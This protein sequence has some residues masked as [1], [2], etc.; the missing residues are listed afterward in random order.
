MI[1]YIYRRYGRERAAMVCNVVTLHRRGAIRL[2]A[3]GLGIPEPLADRVS[4]SL[5][6]LSMRS[7][8]GSEALGRIQGE[9]AQAG[10]APLPPGLWSRWA[11]M[12]E[13]LRGYPRHLSIHSGGFLLSDQRIDQ[14]VPQEPAT[15]PGRTVVQWCKDDLEA[16]NFFKIDILALGMLTAIRK[17]LE[18]LDQDY[19]K[20]MTLAEIPGE[21]RATYE[22]ITKAETIGVFQIES[23]AQRASLPSLRP[24][25]FYDL[26]V[27][28]AIIRPG[29]ILGGV[30][31]PYLKRKRGLEPVTYPSP[32]LEPI[33]NRTFGTIIFQEQLMRVAMAVGGFSGGQADEIRKN[34]GS[35]SAKGNI[36]KWLGQLVEGMVKEGLEPQFI[37]EILR[38]IQGFS[39]YGFPES[40]AASFALLAYSSSWLKRH[41]PAPFF[42]GLLNSQPM[43]FYTPDTLI[44]TARQDGV[45]VRGVSVNHSR[46]ESHLE[47]LPQSPHR[48]ALRLGL[49]LLSDLGEEAAKGLVLE[50]EKRGPY[51]DLEDLTRRT[52]LGRTGRSALA[53]A[54]AF[55]ESGQAR[56]P[57]I[58]QAERPWEPTPAPLPQ[59]AYLESILDREPA[60]PFRPESEM[61]S[62][63]ADYRASGLS[64]GRHLALLIREEAWVYP[65]PV[66]QVTPTARLA[67]VAPGSRITVFGLVLVKQSPG[68]AKKMLFVTLEDEGGT[69]QTT[70]PPQVYGLYEKILERQRFLCLEGIW[71]DQ[72]GSRGLKV[73]RAFAPEAPK[74]SVIHLKKRRHFERL[75][76]APKK[77]IR[78]Y[79]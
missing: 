6:T 66:E 55:S 46:W 24:D 73:I 8:V 67:T 30:K 28:V 77:K 72:Q 59:Q 14:L 22:M 50:R 45:E 20:P 18:M 39:S 75:H 10:Q 53:A 23:A 62:V 4:K 74:A 21:D 63:R 29:P 54:N 61:E 19:G 49:N 57:A 27:Q 34:I 31:H 68:T 36:S 58:W 9:L 7:K 32:K 17:C 35:F 60:V 51:L 71:Q 69:V 15:M 13:A 40:H 47:P 56:R 3:R 5:S 2:A 11:E 1:Q 41:Y 78:A 26:V 64:L 43:G 70:I 25:N 38:Q 44:R 12:T 48:F 42:A 65:V 16:L 76:Q 33:L 37:E 52:G 79:M